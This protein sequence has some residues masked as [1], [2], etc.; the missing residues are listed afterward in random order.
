[1]SDRKFPI[2]HGYAVPWEMVAP[3]EGQILANHYQTMQRI[4]E[5]GGLCWEELYY[6]LRSEKWPYGGDVIKL[7]EAKRFI[8]DKESEFN[9]TKHAVSRLAELSIRINNAC[10]EDCSCG[11]KGPDDPEACDACNILHQINGVS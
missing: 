2:Q 9:G 5:R 6:V 7:E 11:G 3:Y 8:L 10:N 1:M 4:S